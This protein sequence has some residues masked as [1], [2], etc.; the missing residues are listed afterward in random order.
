M[1]VTLTPPPQADTLYLSP[2]LSYYPIYLTGYLIYLT[3]YLI[4][5]TGYLSYPTYL[6]GYYPTGVVAASF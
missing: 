1:L 3:G 5:L 6:K 2:N 4:Y